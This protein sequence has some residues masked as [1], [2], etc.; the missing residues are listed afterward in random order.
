MGN[1]AGHPDPGLPTALDNPP[2]LSRERDRP[3]FPVLGFGA[4]QTHDDFFSFSI[5]I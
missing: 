3:R 5:S 4:T 1:A 2:E